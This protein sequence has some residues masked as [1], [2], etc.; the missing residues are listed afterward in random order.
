MRI[1]RPS[2]RAL[3]GG[4]LALGATACGPRGPRDPVRP[5]GG[6]A[7]PRDPRN[8]VAVFGGRSRPNILFVYA[9]QHRGDVV[10]GLG[11]NAAATPSL[12]RLIAEGV[13]FPRA[14]TNAP[15]CRPARFAM[16]ERRYPTQTGVWDNFQSDE[17][18]AP[19]H[20]R[21]I[22]DEADYYTMVIGKTHLYDGVDHTDPYKPLL[23]EWGFVD[24]IEM[25][26][27]TEQK[28]RGSAYSDWLTQTTPTGEVDKY[29]RWISYA[30]QYEYLSPPPDLDPWLL[31]TSDHQDVY[32]GRVAADWIRAYGDERPFYLQLNFPGPHKPFDSTSEYR[33]RFDPAKVA[34]PSPILV[35]PADPSPLVTQM[36]GNKQEAWDPVTAAFLI[37]T[38]YAKIAMVDY[39]LGL[40][41]AAL[42]ETGRLDDTWIVYHSD[43]GEMLADHLLTGKV[44]FYE[45]AIHVPLV[46]R[47]PG[48]AQVPWVCN[49]LTD[50]LDVVRTLVE[51][52][53]L[54]A[55]DPF[56]PGLSLL[57][58]V[59]AGPDAPDA[60]V[61]KSEIIASNISST[62]IRTET[63]KVIIDR[64]LVPLPVTDVYDLAA[65]PQEL[66]N[67]RL[68]PTLRPT[69]DELLARLYAADEAFPPGSGD[70]GTDTG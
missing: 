44:V 18:S 43:H 64:A 70:F 63:H 21:Q 12:D 67:L 62:M 30:E 15:S 35:E 24:S 41:L 17:P 38:Y 29:L 8:P 1:H 20:V 26:G 23:N 34:L 3:L 57:P 9:D 11:N 47:P 10:S 60:Q 5:G 53:E 36:L 40:V 48:G 28:L 45:G 55:D 27:P 46:I 66:T 32:T 4:G 69:V 6:A 54:P 56:A 51:L 68:D 39:A 37:Q 2:R 50:T 65:D 22:R 59:L 19:S 52:A 58:K 13:A 42:E 49:G 33:A 25:L 14:F 7:D 31:A 61:H 16:M